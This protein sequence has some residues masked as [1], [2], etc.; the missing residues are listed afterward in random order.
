MRAFAN[1]KAQFTPVRI[2]A[3]G[4]MVG[5]MAG[6]MA[7][8]MMIN[9]MS[10]GSANAQTQVRYNFTG[11]N[12]ADPAPSTATRPATRPATRSVAQP[13][14]FSSRSR[15]G[16]M[17]SYS[18]KQIVD[19]TRPLAPGTILIKTDERRLYFVLE[20]G[21]AVQYG[22]G[23]G[24][25]GFA[26]RGRERISRKAKWPGW[27]PPARMIERERA[28]GIILPAH[29]PGGPDNPLGARA[30]YLGG[31]LFRIHGTNQPHTIGHAV[32]SGCIR[33]INEEVID[34]YDRVRVGALVIVE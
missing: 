1:S 32:S 9:V 33:M 13:A 11:T 16:A 12:F 15:S 4:F 19:F 30:L 5:F 17:S 23:V 7:W 26:W 25:E 18:G 22:V 10:I 14:V 2:V 31:T 34:L 24:R 27:T 3:A 28:K 6:F 8:A 20:G 21:K 29:M